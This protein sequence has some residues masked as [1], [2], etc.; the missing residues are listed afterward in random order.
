MNMHDFFA[1][2]VSSIRAA[3][4][5]EP[6]RPNANK[7]Y[8]R[9]ISQLGQRLF[10]GNSK[11]VWTGICAPF[12]VLNA[13]GLTACFVE[14]MGGVVASSGL[15]DWVL[16]EAEQNG[17]PADMCG[18]H[19]AVLGAA[20]KGLLPEPEFL[21]ATTSYCSGGLAVLEVLAR[22]FNKDLF[23]LHVPQTD[24]SDNVTYLADQ[25]R[26]MTEFVSDHTGERL[27]RDRL[28]E[29][30]EQS[31]RA[32]ELMVS[33]YELARAIP[34]PVKSKDLR[35]FGLLMPLFM[36]T[37]RAIDI[38]QAYTDEFTLRLDERANGQDEECL[39]LMWL[40]TRIQF[41]NPVIDWLEDRLG[42]CVVVDELNR[43]H[44]S[45]LNPDDPYEGL[46]R[47]MITLGLNGTT[48]NRINILRSLAEEYHI[49]GVINPC[50]W[51]CRQSSGPKGLIEKAF[52]KMDV[53]ALTL[54]VDIIDSRNFAEG[55]LKTR[56][57]AFI[58][59]LK[60]RPRS[61]R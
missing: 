39:R 27:T 58:E 6:D 53:P 54:D 23:V 49:D 24:T 15:G 38:A 5:R 8:A 36:G 20:K 57:E 50:H 26:D 35:N 41:T 52:T 61:G 44:W 30:I 59:V 13:M 3:I 37:R 7:K 4:G 31:N 28:A 43:V 47:R 25:I 16:Q 1:N 56:I 46:A 60:S 2:R 19:R 34:T 22:E 14:F 40:Q 33:M 48:E 51:G 17:Y 21:I 9:E 12:E 11:V 10:S 18:S 42:A 45:G 55:Q 32:R 29:A